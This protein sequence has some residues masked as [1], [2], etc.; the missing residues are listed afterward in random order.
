M[1]IVELSCVVDGKGSL[2][3]GA[4]GADESIG[5]TC[6]VTLEPHREM[7]LPSRSSPAM[8]LDRSA[9]KVMAVLL[10][11]FV[12]S[13]TA[14]V[15][16][17]DLLPWR[18]KPMR[19][20]SP[21][22]LS[23]TVIYTQHGRLRT[24]FKQ[25]LTV[26]AADMEPNVNTKIRQQSVTKFLFKSESVLKLPSDLGYRNLCSK[27]VPKLLTRGMMQ[28]RKENCL[29]LIESYTGPASEAFKGVITCD[30]TWVY[31][32]DPSS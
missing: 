19:L 23:T 1:A 4:T 14:C 12:F 16:I 25:P 21:L 22:P 3:N 32:Y 10:H 7:E 28:A 20:S 29:D 18:F 6:C 17:G 31:H 15:E 2:A 13:S 5:E 11:H 9:A 27:W 24:S 26:H 30:E 8:L